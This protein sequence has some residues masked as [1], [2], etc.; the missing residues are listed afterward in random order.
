MST[1][2]ETFQLDRQEEGRPSLQ[3]PIPNPYQRA[4]V[5]DVLYSDFWIPPALH[6]VYPHDLRV[7]AANGDTLHEL[8]DTPSQ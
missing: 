3:I 4:A 1:K 5:W 6:D 7:L 8:D 2:V